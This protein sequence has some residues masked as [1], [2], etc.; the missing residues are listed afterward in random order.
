M[1]KL[2]GCF[3]N[4]QIFLIISEIVMEMSGKNRGNLVCNSCDDLVNILKV[5]RGIR[6]HLVGDIHQ[7]IEDT[8]Y[9]LE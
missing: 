1:F 4:K 2:C 8:C 5:A 6:C 3:L 9:N 7:N